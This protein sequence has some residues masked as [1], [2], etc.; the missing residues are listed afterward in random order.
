MRFPVLC[1]LALGAVV[2]PLT[3]Q[4]ETRISIQS[5]DTSI[6]IQRGDQTSCRVTVNGRSLAETEA[7][8]ICDSRAGRLNWSTTWAPFAAD[9][10]RAMPFAMR[11]APSINL[12]RSLDSLIR[13]RAVLGITVDTRSR[14]SD[15]FG[16]YVAGVTPSGPAD[17]AGL[18][19]GDIIVSLGGTSLAS[20]AT[21]R[22]VGADESRPYV[23]LIERM[24]SVDV[25]KPIQVEYRRGDATRS[26]SVT[27]ESGDQLMALGFPQGLTWGDSSTD[28]EYAPFFSTEPGRGFIHLPRPDGHPSDRFIPP[29]LTIRTVPGLAAF[30]SALGNTELAPMNEKLGRYFGT[31]RGVL[32]IDTE[33]DNPLG[34]EAGDVVRA[35][36]GRAIR[37]P[38]EL[39]RVIRSY[40]SGDRITIDIT[41]DRKDQ[42]LH[43]QLP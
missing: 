39:G 18:Q 22:A 21:R 8:R 2:G 5:G 9:T 14:D 4:V 32:I 41:R 27:P 23:R 17:H 43:A 36:D 38:G 20:G 40:T 26:I 11:G 25:G 13:P 3:A 35:I 34:L 19:A 33:S 6:A 29:A 1:A 15:R 7:E 30:S 16:A 42:T 12:F 24:A 37:N 31:G 10:A 28:G